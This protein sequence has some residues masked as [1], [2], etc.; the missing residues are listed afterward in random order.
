MNHNMLHRHEN[1]P[2]FSGILAKF[3]LVFQNFKIKIIPTNFD[4]NV[5]MRGLHIIRFVFHSGND[6]VLIWPT[7]MRINSVILL[8][9]E[10]P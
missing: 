10:A 2:D 5:L 8:E 4:Q 6:M 7:L 1:S 9:F 3:H